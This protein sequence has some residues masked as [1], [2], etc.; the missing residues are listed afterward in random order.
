MIGLSPLPTAHPKTFQRLLVR[1]SSKCYLTFSLAMGRSQSF[2]ST[3]S[4]YTPCSD[5]L[6][7][8]LPPSTGLTLLE[9]VTRRLI[10]QKARRHPGLPGLRPLVSVWFQVLFTLLFGV[11]F[12]F[13]SRYLFTIGLLAVFSLTGWCRLVQ[14]GF[15]LPC[16]T[17]DTTSPI[18]KPL[19]GLSPSVD[20]LPR[21][22]QVPDIF[23]FVVLQPPLRR[24]GTGLGC[25]P[26][27]RHYLGNHCCFLFLQVLRCFSSPGL[28]F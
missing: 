24:N 26:F 20:H 27:A 4:N 21:W 8:R 1:P 6:S 2:A 9:M 18:S 22:I 10:M 7:L 15:L 28:L 17:Q 25:F 13:P 3:A 23:D 12:T 11:L 16:L 14:T 5:S 19:T